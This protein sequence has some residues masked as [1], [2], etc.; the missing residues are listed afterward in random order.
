[1]K[2]DETDH[3]NIDEG[4]QRVCERIDAQMKAMNKLFIDL[5]PEE[6]DT[7]QDI[8]DGEIEGSSQ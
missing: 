8:I 6:V 4:K 7:I 1:M 5:T 3:Q 2:R